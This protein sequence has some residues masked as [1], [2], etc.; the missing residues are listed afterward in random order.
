MVASKKTK[1][2]KKPEFD[3]WNSC[4]KLGMEVHT[5]NHSAEKAETNGSGGLLTS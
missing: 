4:R 2:K 1:Q 5:Y 3:Y